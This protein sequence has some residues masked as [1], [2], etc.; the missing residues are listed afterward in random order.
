MFGCVANLR[1]VDELDEGRRRICSAGGTL[2]YC[3]VS[4]RLA[5]IGYNGFPVV[6]LIIY[7]RV[8]L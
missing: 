1:E 3:C 2:V 4:S 5:L 8:D 6:T 7:Q